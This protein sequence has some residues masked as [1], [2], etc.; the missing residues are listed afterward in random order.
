MNARND[1]TIQTV[2]LTD[3]LRRIL[4]Q[5]TTGELGTLVLE[6][7]SEP[8]TLRLDA[9]YAGT[10]I[11]VVGIWTDS[12]EVNARLLRGFMM[13]KPPPSFRLVYFDGRMSVNDSTIDAKLAGPDAL[14]VQHHKGRG[15]KRR[16]PWVGR[17]IR[18]SR[19]PS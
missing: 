16:M 19:L 12:V 11:H 4:P 8:D 3:A 14:A 15:L 13:R 10:E 17:G 9:Y 1:V 6:P 7:G 5:T 2:D 18:G